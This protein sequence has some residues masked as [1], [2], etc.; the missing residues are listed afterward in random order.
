M[1]N[2]SSKLSEGIGIRFRLPTEA[3]W[4]YACR[5]GTLAAIYAGDLEIVG[6]VNAP[7][8]DPIA[9]YGGN[10]GHEFDRDDGIDVT[11]LENKQYEFQKAA[12]RKVR[13]K[14]PN[15]WGLYDMLD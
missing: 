12:T 3:E 10:S 6:D 8:L 5:A 2:L 4:E 9:W 14:L 11:W 13:K 7:A 15:P 1:Q